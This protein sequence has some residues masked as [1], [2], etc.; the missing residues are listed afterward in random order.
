[1]CL[2]GP[3][4]R[5]CYSAP[6]RQGTCVLDMLS[7]IVPVISEGANRP[8]VGKDVSAFAV[9]RVEKRRCNAYKLVR[10]TFH[11]VYGDGARLL[12]HILPSISFT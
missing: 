6:E 8:L 10:L 5:L 2:E 1:M 12:F 3:A 7:R 9:S 11:S 4:V